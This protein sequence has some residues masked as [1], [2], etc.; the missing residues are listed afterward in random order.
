MFPGHSFAGYA[1]VPDK[2]MLFIR[3]M[4]VN[5]PTTDME[6]YGYVLDL[7]DSSSSDFPAYG[8]TEGEYLTARDAP[9]SVYDPVAQEWLMIGGFDDMYNDTTIANGTHSGDVWAYKPSTNSWRFA[10]KGFKGL[11]PAEGRVAV[12]DTTRNR[13]VLFGGLTGIEMTS[14]E[15]W[16]LTRDGNGNYEAA[17]LAPSGTKPGSRWLCAAVYDAA[18]DRMLITMGGNQAGPISLDLQELSFTGSAQG[19]WT[20]RTATG[21]PTSVAGMG[22]ADK[23]SNKRLYIFG[24]A[25]NSA[26]STVSSQT[27]YLDYSTTSCAWTVV[28]T[29]GAVA[30]RTPAFDYDPGADRLIVFGGFNGTASI[31]TTSTLPLATTV[32]DTIAPTSIP[33]ARRSTIGKVIDGK[34][35]MT[36][37]RSDSAMWYRNTWV[38]Y[39]NYITPNSSVWYNLYARAFTPTYH[40]STGLTTSTG[41][42]WQ[43]WTTEG[44][45]DSPKASH[46]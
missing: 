13:V 38:L 7:N 28:T 16:T 41:Y 26:L 34:F 18:N 8:E 5:D 1:M 2:N 25:T 37:G 4:A 39:P 40:A 32:W 11:P 42:H 20:A 9:T 46:G 24:G 45:I 29:T 19:A 12:Y 44:S 15:V 6:R 10:S 21:S 27:A 36:H 33:D 30:R 22:Y 3:N 35:Y 14:N 23:P 17:K 43:A 31:N